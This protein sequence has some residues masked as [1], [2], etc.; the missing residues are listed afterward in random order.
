[1]KLSV[2]PHLSKPEKLLKEPLLTLKVGR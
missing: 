1:M 2:T